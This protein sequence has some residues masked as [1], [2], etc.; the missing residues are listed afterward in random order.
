M[1]FRLKTKRVNSIYFCILHLYFVFVSAGWWSVFIVLP[2]EDR[3]HRAFREILPMRQLS[4][5]MMMKNTKWIQVD[6]GEEYKDGD[7]EEYKDDDEEYKNDD[8]IVLT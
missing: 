3:Q 5:S 1:M 7:D 8:E 6:N 2:I 4:G